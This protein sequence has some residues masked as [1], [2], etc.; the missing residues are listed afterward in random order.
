MKHFFLNDP[1]YTHQKGFRARCFFFALLFNLPSCLP[2]PS[3]QPPLPPHHHPLL[4][5]SFHM[6]NR[7]HE[8]LFSSCFIIINFFP[9]ASKGSLWILGILG[10]YDC[11][12]FALLTNLLFVLLVYVLVL[13]YHFFDY[14]SFSFIILGLSVL[15]SS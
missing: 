3:L 14:F 12:R 8:F 7:W 4:S 9:Y 1:L 13:F 6:G 10:T 11:E 15:Y 2:I 5:P